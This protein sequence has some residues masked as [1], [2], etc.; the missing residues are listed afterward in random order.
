M[1]SRSMSRLWMIKRLKFFRF[2]FYCFVF[3]SVLSLFLFGALSLLICVLFAVLF[4]CLSDLTRLDLDYAGEG[5]R[6][7]AKAAAAAPPE[8]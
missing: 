6:P 5:V 7:A 8:D 3:G 1:D 2:L 4:F